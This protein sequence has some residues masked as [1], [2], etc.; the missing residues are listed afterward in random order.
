MSILQLNWI[1]FFHNSQFQYETMQLVYNYISGLSQNTYITI[2]DICR[3]TS[4]SSDK[5]IE[6][7]KTL[8]ESDLLTSYLI[9]PECKNKI[10]LI[11]EQII[12]CEHC[13]TEINLFILP[14]ARINEM[15]SNV[16][17]NKDIIDDNSY[18]TNANILKNWGKENGYLYY[19][20]TDI[21][22]SQLQQDENPNQYSLNLIQLWSDFWPKVMHI[23]KKASLQLYAKGDAVA[24]VFIDK[25]DIFNTIKE[26]AFYLYK[27]PI[28]KISVYASKIE[29]PKY[30][31]IAFIRSLDKKWDLN[32]PSVT[33]LYR[34]AEYKPD[35]WK[36]ID[37]YILKYWFF[38]E[39]A[40]NNNELP[41]EFLKNGK[42]V[43]Y[44]FI[45]KHNMQYS[46]N[47][48]A[49]YFNEEMMGI[50]NGFFF[51]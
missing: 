36:E 46:G 5:A 12:H 30:L 47:C 6:I 3:N 18:E 10:E 27:N 16:I 20:L 33:K 17:Y 35:V 14:I 4:S 42:F 8:V 29:L 34:K 39:I 19:L 1:K 48:Y 26:L 51:S 41:V 9:C 45:D 22:S 40:C 49:G 11:D 31:E 44:N 38:D 23:F 28:T 7:I 2:E 21:K 32:T 37:N 50:F 24:W 13:D 43:S 25:N 15:A